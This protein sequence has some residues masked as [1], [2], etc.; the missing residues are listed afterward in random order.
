MEVEAGRNNLVLPLPG[1]DKKVPP[2]PELNKKGPEEDSQ[3]NQAISMFPSRE[4]TEE[5]EPAP[6]KNGAYIQMA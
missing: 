6:Q 1:I 5:Y 4:K 3:G 2:L